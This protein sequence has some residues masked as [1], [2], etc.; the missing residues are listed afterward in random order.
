MRQE[1]GYIS[2]K[3][4]PSNLVMVPIQIKI[5]TP[6]DRAI[7]S[8][9]PQGTWRDLEGTLLHLE[10]SFLLD[11]FLGDLR[12][13]GGTL[14]PGG[15]WDLEGTP[16]QLEDSFRLDSFLVGTSGDWRSLG[17]SFSRGTSGDYRGIFY[18]WGTQWTSGDLKGLRGI[19]GTYL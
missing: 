11:S 18:S 9:G 2:E 10:D 7:K 3:V 14:S 5:L 12:G 1:I 19:Q 6:R 16:L 15:P 13:L 8:P 17:D 4:D